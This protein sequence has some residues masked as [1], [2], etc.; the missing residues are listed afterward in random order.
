[1]EPWIN[2]VNVTAVVWSGISGQEAG[3]GLVDVLYGTYNPSGR[4]PYTLGK[5]ATDYG[6]QL[7]TSGSGT[8]QIPYSEGLFIDYRHF[9]QASITPRYEFGF[10]LS[11]TTFK[12]SALSIAG[13][14][15]TGSPATGTGSS[16]DPWYPEE[17][18]LLSST[19]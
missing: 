11:Y 6:T 3:N 15:G 10:G 17:I 5:A 9:D 4:L 8:V 1:M 2:N 7:I 19:T 16:L 12:Y 14:V 18:F 13:S